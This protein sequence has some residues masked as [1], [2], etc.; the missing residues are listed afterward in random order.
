MGLPHLPPQAGP[1]PP[2][3]V[4]GAMAIAHVIR[5][6]WNMSCYQ[7]LDSA[8]KAMKKELS[9]LTVAEMIQAGHMAVALA[10]GS[11][12]VVHGG[13]REGQRTGH[14]GS[15]GQDEATGSSQEDNDGSSLSGHTSY[16][17][18]DV[19][20]G[21]MESGLHGAEAKERVANGRAAAGGNLVQPVS[22]RVG[23]ELVRVAPSWVQMVGPLR[24]AACLSYT[25]AAALSAQ[26]KALLREMSLFVVHASAASKLS[27]GALQDAVSLPVG[28]RIGR[29]ITLTSFDELLNSAGY[30]DQHQKL[31]GYGFALHQRAAV[32]FVVFPADVA[33]LA[34]AAAQS[35][36]GIDSYRMSP[37]VLAQSVLGNA[38]Q[39]RMMDSAALSQLA[40][41]V[42]GGL[43]GL[44]AHEATTAAA[45]A[46]G[47]AGEGWWPGDGTGDLSVEVKR[48]E[49]T[50]IS[51]HSEVN[52]Q[53]TAAAAALALGH[54][55]HDVLDGVDVGE[56]DRSGMV[57]DVSLLDVSGL[58]G[59]GDP[60]DFLD[61]EQV[62]G[63][64]TS[65]QDSA[66]RAR[67]DADRLVDGPR[68]SFAMA[69]A[70]PK[71]S[72][73]KRTRKESA[74][75]DEKTELSADPT[76]AWY[77]R[78]QKSARA[79]DV[80]GFRSQR[81]VVASKRPSSASVFWAT[82][83]D[84]D[85][86]LSDLFARMQ[87]GGDEDVV[88]RASDVAAL[89]KLYSETVAPDTASVDG[90]S[91]AGAGMGL[92]SVDASVGQHLEARDGYVSSTV[93]SS[94]E[95]EVVVEKTI[96]RMQVLCGES[97]IMSTQ[98]VGQ[99][100]RALS[101]AQLTTAWEGSGMSSRTGESSMVS[102]EVA[103]RESSLVTSGMDMAMQL[104]IGSKNLLDMVG[105]AA[106]ADQVDV[107][108]DAGGGDLQ[109]MDVSG[110]DVEDDGSSHDGSSHS[111]G[112]VDMD[113]SYFV[114]PHPRHS[115]IHSGIKAGLGVRVSLLS[116]IESRVASIAFHGVLRSVVGAAYARQAK[117][118]SSNPDGLPVGKTTVTVT[119]AHLVQC[120]LRSCRSSS[121]GQSAWACSPSL[122]VL[123]Y[124]D[125]GEVVHSVQDV[126]SMGPG[127]STSLTM[128]ASPVPLKGDDNSA[129]ASPGSTRSDKS[130]SGS[131]VRV[132]TRVASRPHADSVRR[133][134]CRL[135]MFSC[136]LRDLSA[137]THGK[138]SA[139]E[140]KGQ[141]ATGAG[142]VVIRGCKQ[143]KAYGPI[144]LVC[145]SD[146]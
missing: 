7:R 29:S 28:R 56:H 100:Q 88:V 132:A 23:R 86:A 72:K 107:E 15:M 65:E 135:R 80:N 50:V 131:T 101:V 44:T 54:A 81:A 79:F 47:A 104:S 128:S 84:D 64:E 70:A 110:F 62:V 109:L 133:R 2:E 146:A 134:R 143:E 16:V 9:R 40:G 97:S 142:K 120:A 35:Q 76:K 123:R 51:T 5:L 6:L 3:A 121:N 48:G 42:L 55:G 98:L 14:E 8:P 17:G 1:A 71:K 4:R 21:D 57:G 102:V 78:A 111:L 103:R 99:L 34:Q 144:E 129:V 115:A 52:G 125:R 22:P 36:R 96:K 38:A 141:S 92:E 24:V 95:G 12:E 118:N 68:L 145:S 60:S 13:D 39:S 90:T 119:L 18:S 117:E 26:A 94:D 45:M 83:Q 49:S 122:G 137:G 140:H 108:A 58:S 73:S 11:D 10:D 116:Q 53:D 31:S 43:P 19:E 20:D 87:C 66:G 63:G 139:L 61:D 126:S 113:A 91:V 33:M 30:I 25:I 41:S 69:D 59:L 138:V 74:F 124:A 112:G 85:G 114:S 127:G 130:T 136:L 105:G 75:L 46:S 106:G 77:S 89:T 93:S 67:G 82:R 27:G 32:D 37:T